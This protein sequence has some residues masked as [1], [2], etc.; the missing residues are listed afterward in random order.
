MK[1][2]SQ[3]KETLLKSEIYQM[4][5]EFAASKNWIRDY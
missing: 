1:W 4:S 3:N 2:N 5:L